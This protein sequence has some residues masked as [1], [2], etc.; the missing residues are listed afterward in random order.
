MTLRLASNRNPVIR[1][2]HTS[3]IIDGSIMDQMMFPMLLSDP[4]SPNSGFLDLEGSLLDLYITDAD[5]VI[6]I[7]KGK[8]SFS[9]HGRGCLWK[10]RRKAIC[11]LSLL[12]LT[13]IISR[14]GGLYVKK[15]QTFWSSLSNSEREKIT[16]ARMLLQRPFLAILDS[17]PTSIKG[18]DLSFII[19][20]LKI[21]GISVVL[22]ETF[23]E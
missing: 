16:I 20:L 12:G 15:A 7:L 1:C 22:T 6:S 3:Y 4:I 8:T 18:S 13:S 9:A 14:A 11:I 17:F 19:D 2:S 23:P 10:S 21:S 5:E